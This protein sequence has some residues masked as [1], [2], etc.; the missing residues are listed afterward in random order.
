MPVSCYIWR[1]SLKDCWPQMV[2]FYQ[3][4][5]NLIGM[6]WHYAVTLLFRG[7]AVELFL[8]L[9]LWKICTRGRPVLPIPPS[10]P[11]TWLC[12]PVQS[13]RADDGSLVAWT[14]TSPLPA[15]HRLTKCTH[16]TSLL[17]TKCPGALQWFL[18][19]K[20]RDI[21]ASSPCA[22]IVMQGFSEKTEPFPHI[23]PVNQ[24]LNY[25]SKELL[26]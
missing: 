22:W 3:E 10:W 26:K 24:C 9:Q 8:V 1:R 5:Y 6:Q 18:P 19:G 15:P 4:L 20:L 16:T 11:M 25:F 14:M 21:S 23:F 7:H 2:K 17:R 13:H 12:M